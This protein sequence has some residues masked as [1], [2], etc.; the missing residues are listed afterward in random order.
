MTKAEA[1]ARRREQVEQL[2]AATR[3]VM[4]SDGFQRWTEARRAFHD[5]SV[6]NQLLI[7]MQPPTVGGE[8]VAE[9]ATRVAGF[10]AWKQLERSVVKG[11]RGIRILA[12]MTVKSKTEVDE[13]GEPLVRVFFK[14]VAVFDISQTDGEPL[15]ELPS[16]SIAGADH[17]AL[18]ARLEGLAD[19]LQVAVDYRDLSD[20]AAGGWYSESESLI[21]IDSSKS[22]DERVRTLTH[23]LAHALGVGYRE[24]GRERAEVIVEASAHL[25]LSTLGFDTSGE[26]LSYIASWGE[27]DDLA[28]LRD[29]LGVIDSIASRLEGQVA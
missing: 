25:A 1:T 10:R 27:R 20:R 16:Q 17:G 24:Y 8:Q 19:E 9:V 14:S 2:E 3:S 5:Y 11:A 22:V 18:L 28:A 15:A 12:P 29:D 4:S 6:G 21:V 13:H 26:A 23:E 7:A